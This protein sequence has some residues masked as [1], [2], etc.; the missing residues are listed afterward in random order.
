MKAPRLLSAAALLLMLLICVSACVNEEREG[1]ATDLP[2]QATEG[3][4]SADPAATGEALPTDR[5]TEPPRD[6]DG[7]VFSHGGGFYTGSFDL[8]IEAPEGYEIYYTTDGSAP[9]EKSRKFNTCI[10]IVECQSRY[11]GALI[12]SVSSALGYPL[13]GGKM[14]RARVIRAVGIDGEGK[15]TPEVTETYMV[16]G[17]G[18]SLFNVP[19]VS[20]FVEPGEFGGDTGIYY[21][22]MQH[23]FD[24]KERVKAVC[25][26]YDETGLKRAGQWV[27]I[28]LSGNGSLG[29]LQKSIR[30]YF[31]S[32]ANPAVADNP[33]KLEYDIFR[34]NVTDATGRTITEFKRLVMRNSGN[35]AVGSFMADRVSQKL[36]SMLNVDYQEARSVILLING[37]LWGT[38][39]MRE[40]YGAKYFAAHYGILEEN[41][42]MLE[43]PTP[44]VT[45]NGN[46]P[47]ELTD[48]TEKDKKDW[49]DLVKFITGHNMAKEENYE[50][51]T[52]QLDVDSLIDSMVAHMYVCNGDWPTNNIKVWRCSSGKDPSRLD[53]K[54]RFVV[55][56][57]DGGFVSDPN[58][59]MFSHAL[60]DNTIL[61][62][63]AHRLLKNQAFRDRFIERC[64]YAAEVVF[65]EKR[66]IKVIDETRAEMKDAIKAN[67]LRWG[68][69]GTNEEAWNSKIS[70]MKRFASSRKKIWLSQLYAYFGITP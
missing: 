49:E 35:D 62:S 42:A 2:A 24:T 59:N 63:V 41:F 7:L 31:K 43:A 66:C 38:Y 3:A 50:K 23:P 57:M 16:W 25:E 26:I 18:A 53:T 28:S 47:Y 22:T 34:G 10:R 8:Y 45:H 65:A 48:G 61:G 6:A 14:P 13:P 1:T 55:M 58:A 67:F 11:A 40:R 17:D 33:G 29:N 51:V 20:L 70:F 27:E 60:N 46:S 68:E 19:V 56:D 39:N 12:K 69:A 4:F 36:A 64:I 37:E 32:D 9:D 30:L 52:A 15:R 21:T 54:W 44:L 5:A